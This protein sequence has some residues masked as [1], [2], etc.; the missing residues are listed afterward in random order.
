[1]NG[2]RGYSLAETL[3]AMVISGIVLSLVISVALGQQRFYRV[4]ADVSEVNSLFGRTEVV[5]G[6]SLRPINAAAGDLVYAGADSMKIRTFSG[7]F[8]ACSVNAGSGTLSL[9]LR[10]LTEGGVPTVGD[11]ALVYS[12]G[13]NVDVLDDGWQ[14][15]FLTSVSSG[16]CPDGTAGWT[17]ETQG[18]GVGSAAT[19]PI[20]APLRLFRHA[21]YW[22]APQ[23]EG[24]FL[25]TDARTG[26]P[27]PA[28]GPLAP[29]ADAPD[30]EFRYLDSQGLPATGAQVARVQVD[31]TAVGTTPRM[32]GSLVT[33]HRTHSFRLRNN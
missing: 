20:G 4:A 14:A 27:M 9:T 12:Q 5:L 19:I 24:W 3:L 25:M 23:T 7:A 29:S 17:V 21:S 16:L 13:S 28:A 1:M 26:S 31:V 32:G 2:E 8:S 30:L 11:S 10:R 33:A 22:F 18:P 6:H 15:L